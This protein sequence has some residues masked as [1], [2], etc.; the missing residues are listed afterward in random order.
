MLGRGRTWRKECSFLEVAH[1]LL[2][3][4]YTPRLLCRGT[5]GVEECGGAVGH[6]K[7]LLL[8]SARTSSFFVL[9]EQAPHGL[10]QTA[11]DSTTSRLAGI[12]AQS[13][14]ELPDGAGD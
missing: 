1:P 4:G 13:E 6:Q 10:L 8:G 2:A 12:R 11:A 7:C 5:E 9:Q 3:G 14:A